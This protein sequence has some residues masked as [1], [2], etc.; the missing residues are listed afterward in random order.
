MTPRPSFYRSQDRPTLSSQDPSGSR[1]ETSQG[2][3]SQPR[4]ARPQNLGV[5]GVGPRPGHT[6][7]Y[8][9]VGFV[10]FCYM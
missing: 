1:P 10:Q 5:P 9:H 7:R 8:P 3:K 2:P 6:T 4:P